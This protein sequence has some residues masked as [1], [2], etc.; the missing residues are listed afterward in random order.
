MTSGTEDA[1]SPQ[2]PLRYAAETDKGKIR[3]ENQD[4]FVAEPDAGIF[5]VSDGMG[6]H[7]G[8]ALAS[9][10]VAQ[11]LP[12]VIENQLDELRVGTARTIRKLLRK[13]IAEQSRQVHLEGNSES[14]FTDMG[15]TLVTALVR[16][17]R[18]FVANVG[19]SRMYR[20]RNNRL[21]RLTKDH[22]VISELIEQGRIEPEQAENHHA[23]GQITRYIGMGEKIRPYIRSFRLKKDDRL[24][25]CTD[26]LTDMLDDGAI[27]SILR[28]ECNGEA[29][30]RRLVDAANEAGGHDNIT[31]VIIDWLGSEQHS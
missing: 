23:R 13:I 31:A 5:V 29:A 12:A 8:G 20:L 19:D 26:G 25:L 10:I 3:E 21:T 1:E 28:S 4:A 2:R 15:A 18:C 27:G 14:G 11:D 7:R 9:E 22:S 16:K 17:G 24:L 6:G 30:C